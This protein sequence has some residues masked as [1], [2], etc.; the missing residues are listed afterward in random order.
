MKAFKMFKSTHKRFT[1]DKNPTDVLLSGYKDKI[2]CVV[3]QTG[4][5]GTVMEIK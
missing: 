4:T 1:L 2:F 3:T 5:V